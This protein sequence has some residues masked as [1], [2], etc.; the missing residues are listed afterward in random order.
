MTVYS[1]YFPLDTASRI[2]DL[3]LAHGDWV[4]FAA[5]VGWFK[6]HPEVAHMDF[7]DV[8]VFLRKTQENVD[9]DVGLVLLSWHALALICHTHTHTHTHTCHL[10]GA[11]EEHEVAEAQRE[12]VP[13]GGR[14]CAQEEA[15]ALNVIL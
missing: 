1:R 9:D 5:A 7:D 11:N 13:A 12:A 14:C 6:M 4:L 15:T 3:W 8:M 10:A 2:W